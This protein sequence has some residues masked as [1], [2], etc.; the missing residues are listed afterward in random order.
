MLFALQ[1]FAFIL[2]SLKLCNLHCQEKAKEPKNHLAQTYHPSLNP[3]FRIQGWKMRNCSCHQF[4]PV[5][6]ELWR[7]FFSMFQRISAHFLF[8]VSFEIFYDYKLKDEIYFLFFFIGWTKPKTL[9]LISSHEIPDK[10]I[11]NV[12]ICTWK[13]Q[14]NASILLKVLNWFCYS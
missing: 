8:S 9:S 14:V 7:F 3:I 11:P 5:D 4:L 1:G 13:F 6:S 10:K 12:E 2:G